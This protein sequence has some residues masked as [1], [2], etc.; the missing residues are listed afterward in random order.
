MLCA[1]MREDTVSCTHK[2]DPVPMNSCS[3]LTYSIFL[4][5]IQVAPFVLGPFSD[6]KKCDLCAK[7]YGITVIGAKQ[8]NY[9]HRSC[10]LD[11]TQC[12]LY[13]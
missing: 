2:F 6:L 1:Y 9:T 3:P 8:L 5:L 13:I 11:P 12:D 7:I 4:P 10:K